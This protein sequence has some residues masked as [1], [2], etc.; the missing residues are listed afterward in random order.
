MGRVTASGVT[1]SDAELSAFTAE[2]D[3]RYGSANPAVQLSAPYSGTPV[4]GVSY[5]FP[6]GSAATDAQ[7]GGAPGGPA[8]AD[9]QR[10]PGHQHRPARHH[11]GPDPLR[12]KP[13]APW[14]PPT[15]TPNKPSPTGT[16]AGNVAATHQVDSSSGTPVA[17]Q[18]L[19]YA[20]N[21]N[22]QKVGELDAT[23]QLQT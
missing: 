12:R 13:G 16:A 3:L 8:M 6:D 11:P 17:R 7:N 19:R 20:W 1:A 15:P 14:W 2:I 9:P 22:G 23:G 10:R 21:A 5:K 4:N 18:T